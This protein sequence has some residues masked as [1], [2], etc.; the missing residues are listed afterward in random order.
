MSAA[1]STLSD[2]DAI[3]A[4]VRSIFDAYLRHDRAAIRATHT[5]DWRGFQVATRQIVRG[6][7]GYMEAAEDVLRRLRATRYELLDTEVDVQGDRALVWYVARDWLDDGLGGERTV[8]LRALDVYRREKAGWNQCGSHVSALAEGAWPTPL[9]DAER[10]ALLAAR[11]TVWRAFFAN[12]QAALA[13][14]L[15]PETIAVNAGT[16]PWLDRKG[17]LA[18]AEEWAAGGLRLLSL[19]FERT[20]IQRY[21][22]VAILY[23]RYRWEAEMSGERTSCAGRATEIFVRRDGA[24]LNAGWHL[25]SGR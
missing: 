14:L 18:M 22:D 1:N 11:E 7:P 9:T 25:D 21:G 15:P 16:E 20:D 19:E 23:P 2:R 4:H 13:R 8:L 6:L 17:A 5:E 3:V 12:D 10:S 24:W